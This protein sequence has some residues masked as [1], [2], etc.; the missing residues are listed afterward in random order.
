[1]LCY[2]YITV[3]NRHIVNIILV[4]MYA[5]VRTVCPLYSDMLICVV[6]GFIAPASQNT[7]LLIIDCVHCCL[8]LL[9]NEGH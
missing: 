1:M 3:Y 5:C 6:Y 9:L 7:P 8:C 4:D 2:I